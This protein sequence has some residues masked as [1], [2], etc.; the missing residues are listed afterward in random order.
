MNARLGNLLYPLAEVAFSVMEVKHPGT[1]LVSGS[2]NRR[3]YVAD[4]WVWR[5]AAHNIQE[6]SAVVETFQENQQTRP[7]ESLT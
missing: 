2:F 1:K 5:Y 4:L 6:C 3:P 7:K